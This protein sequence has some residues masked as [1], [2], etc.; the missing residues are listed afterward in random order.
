MGLDGHLLAGPFLV[1]EDDYNNDQVDLIS[2]PEPAGTKGLIEFSMNKQNWIV[3]KS[4]LMDYSFMWYDSPHVVSLYPTF[5]PVKNTK[6]LTMSIHGTNFRCPEDDCKDLK[7]RFGKPP[8]A[9]YVKG[10]LIE[11]GVVTC[12]V[13]KYTKPDVLEVEVSFNGYDYTNDNLTF[14]YYDPYVIDVEPR[15]L[16]TDGTTDI[17]VK[18]LGFVD[19]GETKVKY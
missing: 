18:G 5:G 7:V 19:S 2:P 16:A 3:V 4:P 14:G 6:N 9:I 1:D 8:E 12:L 11:A 10:E 13:P 17:V 15:L